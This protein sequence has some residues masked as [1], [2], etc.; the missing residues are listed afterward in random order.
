MSARQFDKQYPP[1]RASRVSPWFAW[2][3]STAER[4]I[5]IHT[6]TNCSPFPPLYFFTECKLFRYCLMTLSACTIIARYGQNVGE[7]HIFKHT[8]INE[9]Y[10]FDYNF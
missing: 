8:V 9:I 1:S 4:G 2:L 5:I 10:G 6:I 7:K 3:R